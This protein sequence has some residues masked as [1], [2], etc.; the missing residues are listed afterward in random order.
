MTT[1]P[2]RVV[3]LDLALR[4]SGLALPDGTLHTL[5]IP[6]RIRGY[7]RHAWLAEE[8]V[9]R[10]NP[11]A[12]DLVSIEAYALGA[13]GR[14]SL[15]R[16]GEAG[17]LVRTLFARAGWPWIEVPQAL[18]K[19][20][21]TGRGNADK[22]DVMAAAEDDA[23]R[24]GLP[25]PDNTDEADAYWLRWIGEDAAAFLAAGDDLP[26]SLSSIDTDHAHT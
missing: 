19:K 5:K 15:V 13:P 18:V 3:G 21:A 10:L 9:A 2:P 16:L 22:A 8:L 7:R 17:G 12:P 14:L 24:R 11:V 26:G 4:A 20:T 1:D 6:N 25:M 23:Q